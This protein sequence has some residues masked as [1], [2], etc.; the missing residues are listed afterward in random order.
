[1][2]KREV[3]FTS[4]FLYYN[5]LSIFLLAYTEKR[6]NWKKKKAFSKVSDK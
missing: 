2:K 1:M 4:F 3:N 5:D 6:K